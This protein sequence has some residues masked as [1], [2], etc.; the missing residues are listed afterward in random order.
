M[1]GLFLLFGLTGC[2]QPAEPQ[3]I[4]IG[5]VWPFA[6]DNDLFNEG[7][8]L[9]VKEINA[10]GGINGKELKLLKEDDGSEVV[11]GIAIAESLAENKSVRAVIGHRNS[12]VSIPAAAIYEQAGL[13]M[14]SPA[15]TAPEL[16][17]NNY[18]HIFRDLPGD[19]EIARQLANHLAGQGLRRLVI[20]YSADAYG[21][22][23]ANSFEDAAKL[24]GITIVDRFNYYSGPEELKRLHS[25][26]QAFG[27]DGVFIASS[28]PGGARLIADAGQIGIDGPFAA[29]NALDAP[30]LA[31][32]GGKAA[33]GTVV[34]SVFDPG[35]DRPEVQRFVA[36]FRETYREKPSSHAALGYDAV[37]M[38]AAAMEKT[39]RQDRASV[40]EGLR[41]LGRWPGVC[42]VHEL[43]AAGDDLG[44]LVVLKQLQDGE[45]VALEK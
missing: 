14:L 40:A 39:G 23:L 5:V 27:F 28:L 12:F 1:L 36:A 15:S 3:E 24:L 21:T 6:A 29:G 18:R 9:A 34:G 31:A 26:W 33:A 35:S 7:I 10:S 8:D 16:T 44:D 37:K 32:I 41:N 22:G 4:V 11:K 20:Y 30:E 38:L 45:F 25:R 19:E 2:T 43:S 13:T 42:G 17:Q